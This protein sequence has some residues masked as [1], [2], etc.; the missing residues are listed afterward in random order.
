[1]PTVRIWCRPSAQTLRVRAVLSSCAC[2]HFALLRT[3]Y[4]PADRI[5][6]WYDGPHDVCVIA[7]T[8][9]PGER[10]LTGRAECG[11]P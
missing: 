7:Q 8:R 6:R 1:M 9:A 5:R 4:T 2:R 10:G 3:Q 11:V